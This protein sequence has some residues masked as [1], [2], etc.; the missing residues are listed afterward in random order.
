MHWVYERAL[1]RA[2]SYGIEGVT[3]SLTLGV[4]KSIIPAIASTNALIASACV[5]E[6]IKL[7]SYGAQTMDNYF[8][9]MGGEGA[10][11]LTTVYERK[12]DC[13]AC[14]GSQATQAVGRYT[15]L[16]A[17]V[18]LLKTE[19]ALQ[20]SAPTIGGSSGVLY[21]SKPPPALAAAMASKLKQTLPEL[22]IEDGDE[23]AVT[24]PI[25]PQEKALRLIIK[26]TD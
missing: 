4:V 17:L 20:L 9:Y 24:D 11:S 23:L 15:T 26:Y 2:A 22:G 12:S 18:D 25:W 21:F 14:G 8:M 3:Y 13:T 5:L 16:E 19:A 10:Y 6:C 7:V 1:E